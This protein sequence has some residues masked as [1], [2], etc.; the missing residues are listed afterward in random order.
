MPTFDRSA[1]LR[2]QPERLEQALESPQSL[3][4]PLWRDKTVLRGN[5]PLLL[6]VANHDPLIERADELVWLG[7]LGGADCFALDFSS[8]EEHA[9]EALLPS[10]ATLMDLRFAAGVGAN[11]LELLMF[12]KGLLHWHREAQHC[13]RCGAKTRPREGG[14]S[15]ECTR[16]GTKFFPRTDPAIMLAIEHDERLLIARQPQFPPGMYSIL[17][18]FVEPGE[19]LEQA[20]AREALEE[21][22][23]PVRDVR[24]FRSQPW[25]F[26]QSLMIGFIAVAEHDAISLDDEELEH[27]RWVTRDELENPRDFVY[28]PPASLAHHMIQRFMSAK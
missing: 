9:V 26:P 6:P 7:T 13:G 18:G 2:T 12:A 21:V 22:G 20:A 1:Q 5:E 17:A 10:P 4:I 16:E 24:Y 28:P 8:L 23:L 25:P 14:H 3:L 11:H 27:A 19:T 15:R